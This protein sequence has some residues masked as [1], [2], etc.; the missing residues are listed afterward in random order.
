MQTYAS[1]KGGICL[2]KEYIDLNTPLKWRCEKGHTWDADFEIIRQGGWCMA[3]WSEH[4]R[5]EERL[6]EMKAIAIERG[7]KCLS[8][9]Y[10][11]SSS[12]LLWECKEGH[13]W[14]AAP[15]QVKSKSWCIK[16]FHKRLAEAK[17]YD[18][19][20]YRKIASDRGGKLL[21]DTYA[22]CFDKMEWQCAEGHRWKARPAK[23]KSGNWCPHCSGNIKY[24]LMDT[25]AEAKKH[26][27]KFLSK[28]YICC[29]T[30]YKWLCEEGHQWTATFHSILGGSWCAVC[31][32]KEGADKQR[33]TLDKYNEIAIQKGGKCI[34]KIYMGVHFK[35][36]WQCAEG[37]TWWATPHNIHQGSWCRKCY[38]KQSG[39]KP[40][41]TIEMFNKIALEKGGRCLSKI[42]NGIN[43]KLEWKC[44]KG[45]I[46]TATPSSIKKGHWCP[47]CAGRV[48][49]TMQDLKALAKERG[50]KCLSK[51]YI[52]SKINL[53]WQCKEG[54]RWMAPLNR[55]NRG[56]WCPYCNKGIKLTIGNMKEL[57]AQ[58]SGKCLSKKY[59]NNNTKLEWQCK[60]GHK[61][62]A[63][64]SKIQEGRWCPH[65]HPFGKLSIQVMREL[66]E[67]R[68]GICLSNVY[69]D[70]KT[71]LQW[72]CKEGHQWWTRPSSV[73]N[74]NTWCPVCAH[75][76]K[77]K[78]SLI[79]R[80]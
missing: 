67:K 58:K 10:I 70:S 45:H 18:I 22:G 43:A 21:T 56:S 25:I 51:V 50:G 15:A 63:K 36:K 38:F 80:R 6:E 23:I 40:I 33:G 7:G 28:E 4:K 24:T 5:K 19:E 8:D 2:S 78:I 32:A 68:G 31:R 34:S 16:C 60:K 49:P 54:H 12:K 29:N 42:Y 48:K 11:N 55:I 77:E 13:Q 17:K 74:H 53:E 62:M 30:N 9:V 61:W 46:W 1:E 79:K 72:E 66:A 20:L 59:I 71:K 35:L 57:A 37:H 65:C 52:T 3:C 44:N 41:F 64:P 69:I 14:K 73:K 47:D 75:K 26:G 39:R 27:G 76:P